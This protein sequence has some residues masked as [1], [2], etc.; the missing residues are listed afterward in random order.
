VFF[1]KTLEGVD[2]IKGHTYYVKVYIQLKE[3]Q[4][5]TSGQQ[6]FTNRSWKLFNRA[7][8]Q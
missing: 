2:S 6:K 5:K 8:C 3:T 4:I 7:R 1:Y